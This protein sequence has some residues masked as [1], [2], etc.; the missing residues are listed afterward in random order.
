MSV[1]DSPVSGG[2]FLGS[3][4]R[5]TCLTRRNRGQF[6]LSPTNLVAKR[7]QESK[8]V[9]VTSLPEACERSECNV[10]F[11]CTREGKVL[12]VTTEGAYILNVADR[13]MSQ[14]KWNFVRC[15]VFHHG[16]RRHVHPL[17]LSTGFLVGLDSGD[18]YHCGMDG[19]AVSNLRSVHGRPR[20]RYHAPEP[21]HASSLKP[22]WNRSTPIDK[23]VEIH[24][25]REAPHASNQIVTDWDF[26][27]VNGT[28]INALQ[29]A[30]DHLGFQDNRMGQSYGKHEI[31][32]Y[33]GKEVS[34]CETFSHCCFV[35]NQVVATTSDRL[36]SPVRLWDMR[37][38]R[39]SVGTILSFPLDA[40]AADLKPWPLVDGEKFS[41]LSS[42]ISGAD[43]PV[44]SNLCR[45]N[46]DGEIFLS[47]KSDRS[48]SN[49]ILD[50]VRSTSKTLTSQQHSQFWT[51]TSCLIPLPV[52]PNSPSPALLACH[53]ESDEIDLVNIHEEPVSGH[54]RPATLGNKRRKLPRT[55]RSVGKLSMDGVRDVYG[56]RAEPIRLAWD[57]QR[58]RL[59]CL[60]QD[61]GVFA[62]SV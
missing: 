7:L 17:K 10:G 43:Q 18:Y 46:D 4:L 26:L 3:V 39:K 41:S 44:V 53:M 15:P 56:L 40:S 62:W 19:R 45:L 27:E 38:T 47:C 52:H 22:Q 12:C 48:T 35:S 2:A 59:L 14:K 29:A 24:S 30:S 1:S 37:N 16:G 9:P 20:R 34:Y 28:T 32:I 58:H 6:R 42:T 21:R 8:A 5:S 23:L 60:S 25:W 36:D 13:D 11:E 50:P 49:L 33:R 51:E 57:R 31:C 55:G 61:F 54:D